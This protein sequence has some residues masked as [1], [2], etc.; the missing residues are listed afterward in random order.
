VLPRFE[1]V[2][3][4]RPVALVLPGSEG[5]RAVAPYAAVEAAVTGPG[6][7]ELALTS[8]DVALV[9]VRDDRGLS[10][11]ITAGG[12]TTTHRSRR[13][14]RPEGAVTGLALTL[15]GTQVVVLAHEDDGWRARGR[16]DLAD[17]LDPHDETWLAGLQGSATGPVTDVRTGRFGQVGLRDLRL[18]TQ[19]DGTP[20]RD[21]DGVLLTASSA[22]PGHFPT[23]HTSVWSFDPESFA[24]THRS[25]L[26]FRRPGRHGRSGGSGVGVYGDHATH[27]VRDGGTW[28]VA[29]STWGDFDRRHGDASVEV[30]LAESDA[31]LTTGAHVL[32][33]HPLALPTTGLRSVGVWDPHLVR[34]RGGWLAG[35]VSA[36]KFFRFHPVVAEGPD[37]GSLTLRAAASDR[38]ATEGT[39]LQRLGGAWR[40]LASDGRAGRRGQRERYPVFDLDLVET[41]ALDAPYPTNLPWPTLLE[42][43]GR[44]LMI[45]FNGARW[46]GP[47]VGYGSH[48]QVVVART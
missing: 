6:R 44:W 1:I 35:Y 28:R 10:L 4:A 41:G 45:G 38:R 12:R 21:G 9:G 31:D 5:E 23:A 39:T 47:L 26:F 20:Y 32:D 37:L 36:T 14:G 25:D 7:A 46:G 3:R 2:H 18:V 34:T 15:T 22:G 42:H 24:L 13:H 17:R 29:T 27:L 11:T 48:G 33:S 43:E 40:V 8:H 19:S 30:T 16:V